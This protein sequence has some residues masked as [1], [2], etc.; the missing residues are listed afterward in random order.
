MNEVKNYFMYLVCVSLL[1]L[2]LF[3]CVK[4]FEK[5]SN[6]ID[7]KIYAMVNN[8]DVEKLID[9]DRNL[10]IEYPIFNYKEIDT[11]VETFVSKYKGLNDIDIKYSLNVNNNILIILFVINNDSIISYKNINYDM[12]ENEFVNNNKIIDFNTLGSTILESVKSKYRKDIYERIVKD[13]FAS[14][15]FN[16]NDDGMWIYFDNKLFDNIKYKVYVYFPSENSKSVSDTQYDKVIAFTFDDG[17]SQYTT[18][19]VDT[20]IQHNS[21]ATFFELG[22]RM[23]YNQDIVREVYNKGMEIGSHTY[24]HKNLNK[25]DANS[26]DEEIN[27]TNII[28]NEI[29]GDNIKYVRPPYGNANSLVRSRI[30][31]PIINWN[32]DT[33][34]WLTRDSEATYNHILN[35]VSDGDIVLMHDIYPETIEAVK[36]VLPVLKEMGY[37]VTTISELANEKGRVLE[38]GVIY[39]S[40]KSG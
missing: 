13:N 16:I 30:V 3:S 21:K 29:T 11:K 10:N 2:F 32:V 18:D 31:V 5:K 19:L 34:D 12:K 28:Y 35:N 20:L 9:K 1:F 26:I 7:G 8:Y 39:R 14:A 15:S 25:L 6:L 38:N 4:I 17:P 23:K 27:S 37:K 22:N 36:M 40:I 33:N 24:A